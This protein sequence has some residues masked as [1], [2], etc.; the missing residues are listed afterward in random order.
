VGIELGRGPSIRQQVAV[1]LGAPETFDERTRWPLRWEPV[2]HTTTLPGFVGTLEVCEDDDG[3]TTLQVAGEYRPPLGLVGVIIDG[4]IG[5][6][7]AEASV[8]HFVIAL[9]RRLDRAWVLREGPW[10]GA[11]PAPDL[12]PA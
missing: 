8:E 3:T 7:V 9:A 4:A 5:H 10:R 2:G 1:E 6:R 11:E 12:R